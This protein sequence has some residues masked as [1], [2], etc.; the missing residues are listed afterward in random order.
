LV[1]CEHTDGTT[2]YIDIKLLTRYCGYETVQPYAPSYELI[3]MW[4]PIIKYGYYQELYPIHKVE[5]IIPVISS[6]FVFDKTEGK[7]IWLKHLLKNEDYLSK[8]KIFDL[9]SK[10]NEQHHVLPTCYIWGKVEHSYRIGFVPCYGV[11]N[12]HDHVDPSSLLNKAMESMTESL[13]KIQQI[14]LKGLKLN[15]QADYKIDH[16]VSTN[17]YIP[18]C[19]IGQQVYEYV[20]AKELSQANDGSHYFIQNG[21]DDRKFRIEQFGCMVEVTHEGDIK[22]CYL[23][24]E[25]NVVLPDSCDIV[26]S[27]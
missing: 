24:K 7:W 15:N 12:A 2:Q 14:N 9:A 17:C 21:N 25:K 26:S 5:T 3:S 22:Y 20:D 16:D 27:A 11:C 19:Q 4:K 6:C 10:K 23:N 13:E 1:H 8:A 18:V